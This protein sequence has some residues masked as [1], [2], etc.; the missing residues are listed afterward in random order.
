MQKG[1]TR[2]TSTLI[3]RTPSAFGS[4]LLI[5]GLLRSGVN[6][7]PQQ[8]IV[9][10]DFR[11]MTYRDLAE[12]VSRLAS[13]LTGLG[14]GPGDTVGVM[15]WDTARYLECFFAVPMMGAV[16]HTINVRLSPEQILCTINHAE[17]DVILV[18]SEFLPVLEQIWE[19]VE[20]GKKLMLL[21]DSGQVHETHLP[22]RAL[23]EDHQIRSMI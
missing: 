5:G 14:V 8:E 4:P 21:D 10:A 6:R 7:A 2:M 13:G 20:P 22:L 9:Y 1:R 17:D 23:P 11:R 3:E 16:L 18:N 12:R 15:D 19:R